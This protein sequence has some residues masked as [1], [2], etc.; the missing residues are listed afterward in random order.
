[1]SEGV[2]FQELTKKV[3]TKIYGSFSQKEKIFFVVN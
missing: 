1:M 2:A 3:E